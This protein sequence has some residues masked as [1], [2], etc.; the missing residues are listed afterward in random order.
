MRDAHQSLLATRVRTYDLVKIA[1]FAAHHLSNA[2]SLEMWGGATF[3]VAM[4]FL[5]EDPWLRLDYLRE[6]VPNIPFQMLLRGANAVGY[7]NYSDNVVYRF[8]ELA[9]KHGL[10]I[11]RVFDS[12]NYLPNLKVG[13]DAARQSGGVV[14]GAISYTGDVSNPE[15]KKYDLDYYMK[16]AEELVK[17]GTHILCIKVV[18]LF[19]FI[20]ICFI[21]IWLVS[22]IGIK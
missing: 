17:A 22:Y 7:T 6:R 9:Y 18:P 15:R 3:D 8:C 19:F 13:M 21:N 5:R 1:P 11:F 14:E 16:F 10:D 20:K 4:R 2:C 12:L